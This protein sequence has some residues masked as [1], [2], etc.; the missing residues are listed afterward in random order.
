MYRSTCGRCIG[1]P[2]AKSLFV[3]VKSHRQSL[4]AVWVRIHRFVCQPLQLRPA[5]AVQDAQ[6]VRTV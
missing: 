3:E 5:E 4:K 2:H 6:E 1:Q